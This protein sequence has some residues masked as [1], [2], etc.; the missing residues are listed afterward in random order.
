M[1]GS[2]GSALA[3]LMHFVSNYCFLCYLTDY[4]SVLS[5]TD[6]QALLQNNDLCSRIM[7]SI[8]GYVHVLG[9]LLCLTH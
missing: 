3:I 9:W 2:D 5:M 7:Y 8:L 1:C 6:P 4:F